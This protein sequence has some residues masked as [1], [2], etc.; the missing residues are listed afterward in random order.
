MH[1][2]SKIDEALDD[3]SNEH[4]H[5]NKVNLVVL[6]ER[7]GLLNEDLMRDSLGNSGQK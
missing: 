4:N 6:F 7:V 2:R 1:I 3:I 5:V